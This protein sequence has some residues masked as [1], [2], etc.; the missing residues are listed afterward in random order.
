MKILYD[1]FS[2]SP[3]YGSD[4]GI[5]W[6]WPYMMRRYHE[7]WALVR[8]DRRPDIEKFCNEHGID[9]IHFVYCDIPDWMNFYYKRKAKNKNGTLDFLAYQF[10]WQFPAYKKAKKLNKEIHF[11][12]IHHVSTNDFRLIGFMHKLKVPY[13]IG[14]IGGA[15]ETPAALTYYVRNHQRSEK[16]RKYLNKL[17]I[18]FPGYKKALNAASKVYFSNPETMNYLIPYIKDKDKCELMTEIG[19]DCG[20]ENNVLSREV[21]KTNETIFMWAGRMEYRKGVELL[22]DVLK[23]LPLDK[24][25]Q[26]VLCGDG[27]DKEHIQQLCNR[28]V[29]A[30][31][32]KFMGKLPYAQVQ[33]LYQQATAFVFPSL[34]ETTGTVI[35]EAMAHGVPVICLKQ[36]GGALIVNEN[37]G[38]PI[39]VDNMKSCID[40]FAEVMIQCIDNPKIAEQLGLRARKRVISLYSWPDKIFAMECVYRDIFYSK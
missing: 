34:R 9:D 11:D 12:I 36:G 24:K 37:V 35:I 2:C 18:C 38:F 6:M 4:E 32:V 16:L 40:M 3:Y 15:Q 10:L 8:K 33:K 27:S 5:G 17:M 7:V 22:V 14:P 21:D 1:C 20:N 29:F 30:E 23:K 28:E 31:R 26:V 19:Y 25:W 39:S 13:I